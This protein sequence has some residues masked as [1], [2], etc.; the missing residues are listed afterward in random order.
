MEELKL[1]PELIILNNIIKDPQQKEKMD[2]TMYDISL[3]IVL[4]YTAMGWLVLTGIKIGYGRLSNSFAKVYLSPQ[5][6][7]FLF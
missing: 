6:G 4:G 2:V 1:V 3:L 7:W 5:V